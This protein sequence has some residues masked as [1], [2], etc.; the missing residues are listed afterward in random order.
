MSEWTLIVW[1]Q[2]AES[3]LIIVINYTLIARAVHFE[4]RHQAKSGRLKNGVR[5]RTG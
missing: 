4:C 5:M 3:L 2:Q 1:G